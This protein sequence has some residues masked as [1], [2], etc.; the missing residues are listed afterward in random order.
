MKFDNK[1]NL[2]K[3]N[4]RRYLIPIIFFPLMIVIFLTNFFDDYVKFITKEKFI[5]IATIIYILYVIYINFVNYCYIE[6]RDDNSK[7]ILRYV[8][9]RLFSDERNSIE[10][11]K[12]NF[13]KYN[14]EASFFNLKKEL[15]FFIKTPNGIAK[16]PSI[17]LTGLTKNQKKLLVN[18]LDKYI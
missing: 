10:F 6:Y 17:S 13:V 14:I 16:Y 1:Q 11:E 7:I 5:I 9:V 8:S 12:R 4:V 15:V 3:F 18:S 2:F